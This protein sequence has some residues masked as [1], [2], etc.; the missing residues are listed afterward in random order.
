VLFFCCPLRHPV[1]VFFL[2]FFFFVIIKSGIKVFALIQ[3]YSIILLVHYRMFKPPAMLVWL[4]FL[5]VVTSKVRFLCVL[6]LC[7]GSKM[8]YYL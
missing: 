7:S 6:I 2:L 1:F 3:F 5:C 4:G 8:V